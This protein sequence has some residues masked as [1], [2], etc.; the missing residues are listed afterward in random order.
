MWGEEKALP[1]IAETGKRK[2]NIKIGDGYYLSYT[3]QHT[4]KYTD[5]V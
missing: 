5:N 3:P 2:K 1:C 4:H